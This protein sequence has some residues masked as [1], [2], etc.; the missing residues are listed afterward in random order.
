MFDFS[1]VTQWFDALLRQTCGLSDFWA[2]L[3]ECVLVGLIVL[4]L[5]ALIA[6][7]MIYFERKVCAFFQCRLGPM[8]GIGPGAQ[9]ATAPRPPAVPNATVHG[10]QAKPPDGGA[11]A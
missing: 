2:I 5:Y 6:M 9:R 4:T 7:F 8:R 10:A 3:I 1:K 11:G